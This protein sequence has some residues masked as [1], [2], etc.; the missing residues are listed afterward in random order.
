MSQILSEH[1]G[2][3]V[4]VYIDDIIYSKESKHVLDIRQAM[5]TFREIGV[6]LKRTKCTFG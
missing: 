1:I 5:E 4:L 2:V 3:C 6:K